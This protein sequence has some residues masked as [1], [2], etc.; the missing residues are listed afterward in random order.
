MDNSPRITIETAHK[1]SPEEILE[2]LRRIKDVKL[3]DGEIVFTW[4][5]GGVADEY[6]VKAEYVRGYFTH[7]LMALIEKHLIGVF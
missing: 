4:N 6:F 1:T 2:T 7:N 5:D 3:V